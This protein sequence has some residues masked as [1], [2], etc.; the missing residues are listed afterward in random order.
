VA[1]G[2]SSNTVRSIIQDNRGFMWFGTEN[3]LSRFDGRSFK[4]FRSVYGD[5]TSLGNNYVYTLYEDRQGR[6]WTG[7]EGGV[8][9][10]DPWSEHFSL[11]SAATSDGTT[12]RSH[13]T[14]LAGDENNNI[15]ISTYTQGV[16]RYNPEE[17]TLCRYVNGAGNADSPPDVEMIL[18]LY[19]DKQN[20]V[21]TSPQ[22]GRGVLNRFDPDQDKF[23]PVHFLMDQVSAGDIG[24]YAMLEDSGNNFW[25]GTWSHGLCRFDRNTGEIQP[26]PAPGSHDAISHI[27][28]ITEYDAHTLLIGSDDGL[29]IFNTLTHETELITKS[30]LRSNTL[31]DKFIYPIYKDTE[32][33]LWI[34]TYYGGVNYAPPARGD[35][36]GYAHSIYSN[37]VGGNIVSCFCEDGKGNIWI[38]SDDGG[39]SCFNPG[40]KTFR[41]YMPSKNQNSLSY[42]NI[43]ALCFY[44]DHTLWIGT[45]SGGLNVLDIRTDTF[46][47]YYAG[48]DGTASLSNNSVYSIYKDGDDMWVGTMEGICLY[49]PR[50]DN[51]IREKSI[52][53]TV[54]DIT[55]DAHYLWFATLG[56]GL[57]RYDK[58]ENSW[59]HYMHTPGNASPISDNQINSVFMDD[60]G[61]LWV[62][63]DNGLAFYEKENDAFTTL[64]LGKGNHIICYLVKVGNRLWMTTGNGLINYHIPDG[65]IKS[66]YKSDGLQSDQFNK[67]AGLL[68]RSGDLYL[69]TTNGFNIVKPD[70]ISNNSSVP[71]V[72]ITN[73][74]VF[75][76][77]LE[78]DCKGLLNQSVLFT[79]KIELSYKENVFNIEY[80]AL[81]Y[82]SPYKNLYK[83][84]LDGFDKDWNVVGNQQK[85]TYTSL[86]AGK[87]V[88]HVIGSNND[89]IWN[90]CGAS[91]TIII[92]PPFWRTE[93]AYLLYS[94]VVLGTM[95]FVIHLIRQR[96]EKRHKARI[97]Q[98]Q[99]EKDKELHDAKINFFTLVAHEIRTPVTLIITP[100]EKIMDNIRD[101]PDFM[102][103]NL[104]VID[105]NS[106]RLLSL[107]NQL[108][109]FRKAE[110]KAFVIKF[111]SCNIQELVR[112]I[113]DRFK[114][115]IVQKNITC[116]LEMDDEETEAVVDAEA[117][118]KIVSNLLTNA[119][120]YTKDTITIHVASDPCNIIVKV[121]DNGVGIKENDLQKVFRP[122]YQA[123]ENRQSGTGIGLSLVKLLVDAH[124]GMIE[125][126]S[127][128][129]CFTIFTVTLP[130]M[131]A[132]SAPSPPAG[133]LTEN[134][135]IFTEDAAEEE[136]RTDAANGGNKLALL[137]VED[138][139][140][141]RRFLCKSLQDEYA[142]TEARNGKE[143]LAAL[144]RQ[145]ADI[146]IADIMMPV[147][148]GL[149]FTREVKENVEFSH[150]PLILLT[151]RTDRDFKVE[152]MKTGADAYMEKPFSIHL[153]RAQIE[154]LLESRRKLQKK[155]F[156]TPFIPINSVA[157]NKADKRF[158]TNINKL[159][160]DNISNSD[161]SIDA[162]AVKLLISRSGLFAKMKSLTGMTPNDF[163]RLIRLRKAVELLSRGE[164]SI[165]EICYQTG[166]NNP[167]YFTKCFRKQFG[168]LPK[169]F[170]NQKK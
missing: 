95:G 24:V 122:F 146:I 115:M 106:Q 59:R 137:I 60:D 14:N 44:D 36:A 133:G 65:S 53:T 26:F 38:G 57:F 32:G 91:L 50:K 54:V 33:G 81:S 112:N 66:F 48:T 71:P 29:S 56:A 15:W 126:D 157:E 17:N 4:N 8:Y 109:D 166:F 10:Y 45:Y 46:K 149:A 94:I 147:M 83:Y 13:I 86:P 30:E 18:S 127:K 76:K 148:D 75:N 35:I 90:E 169:D 123:A 72:F 27:H 160:E 105:R 22:R 152:G 73:I 42:C 131:Q 170:I 165:K 144:N 101:M 141:M 39:L 28:E 107:I 89:G 151:A 143:G 118:T 3:G 20:V 64:P 84:K 139:T 70:S 19:I 142:I 100:L 120:K 138:N 78:V 67:K 16:F 93:W 110:E 79:D 128:P 129:D 155:F 80:V 5:S 103:E 51:F 74:Q 104:R 55:G 150:I 43:H 97:Q 34:G 37:S 77:N 159:I 153:L 125:V 63:T 31:S 52:G 132:A 163:I 102:H 99:T 21:W 62:G 158:L 116:S 140:D 156:E 136:S 69:G 1:D 108:L 161:F 113:Y 164:L 167:S 85:A 145:M 96:T 117:F 168:K 121:T 61:R 6:I 135:F 92:H 154:N 7:T 58:S 162:L 134:E 130:R 9:I 49:N 111:A 82:D 23:V 114:P 68:S 25:I 40:T 47:H 98:L 11:F 88:F 2:L 87:Y 124:N 12:V 119:S 41:N